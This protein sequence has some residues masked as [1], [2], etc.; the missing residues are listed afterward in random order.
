MGLG[1]D[2]GVFRKHQPI[3]FAQEGL[4]YMKNKTF[5][6]LVVV[7]ILLAVFFAFAD[8][9]IMQRFANPESV[10]AHFM[11]AYGQLPGIL[12][13]FMG[14]SILL[15]FRLLMKSYRSIGRLVL[16]F[17][18]TTFMGM[19]F[20]ADATGMQV[21]ENLDYP[22]IGVLAVISLVLFQIW[23]RHI[24]ESKL[25]AYKTFGKISLLLFLF[26]NLT[27]WTIKIPWGRWTYRDM[28]KVSDLSLF[29]P[30]YLPQ[31]S[32]GHH[33]F[34]SGHTATAF[35]V[36]P[37]VLFFRRKQNHY[38]V[39]WALAMLWGLTVALSRVTI[40]AHF[41]SDVLFGAGE[42][43]LWFWFLRVSILKDGMYK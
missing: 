32:N 7:F 1:W 5:W 39:A 17:I 4:R 8:L 43:L 18:L 23:L 31:G 20:W 25:E 34:I 13:G 36:L 12:V 30:W 6:V 22:L 33:S 42:T 29:T 14:G 41:P 40:G 37:V 10:W 38:V 27:V 11:Q 3:L 9:T 15:R 19:G 16:L 26:S 2:A 35:C 21:G 24:P 28:L